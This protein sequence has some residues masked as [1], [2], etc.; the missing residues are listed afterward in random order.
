MAATMT[1]SNAAKAEDAATYWC[2][3]WNN[4]TAPQTHGI[5]CKAVANK[6]QLWIGADALPLTLLRADTY[7]HIVLE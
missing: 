1:V 3:L 5:F 6:M 7:C 2:D 4:G